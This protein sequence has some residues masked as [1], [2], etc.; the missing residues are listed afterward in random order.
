MASSCSV[1]RRP[2]ICSLFLLKNKFRYLWKHK[3]RKAKDGTDQRYLSESS[4]LKINS[5]RL[6]E[7]VQ[8]GCTLAAAARQDMQP[9]LSSFHF[10]SIA[11]HQPSAATTQ[12][13][14][15]SIENP[16]PNS[17]SEMASEKHSKKEGKKDRSSHGEKK[18]KRDHKE[19]GEASKSKKHRSKKNADNSVASTQIDSPFHVQ[20]ASL[21]LPLAPISQG[22][23]LEGLCAEHLSPLLL[24]FYPPL[25]GVVLSYNNVTLSESPHGKDESKELLMQNIDEYAVSYCWVTATFLLFKP[26]PGVELEGYVNLQNQG[27]LGIVCWNLFNA[28]IEAKRLPKG[29]RWVDV[30]ELDSIEATE[31]NEN[32]GYAE[33]GV[34]CWVDENN[35]KIEGQIKFR[36][37]EVES[38][39]DRERGFLSLEGTLLSE[40]DE[41]ELA[42]EEASHITTNGRK[43]VS[44]GMKFGATDLSVP[45]E[46]G[47]MDEDD[48]FSKKHRSRY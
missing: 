6:N 19:D 18:R 22:Y 28:S 24:T 31:A 30:S 40:E 43:D 5:P 48:P 1:L 12:H 14:A 46:K 37:K 36:V 25:Q 4:N 44:A 8:M 33:D 9:S 15:M 2:S 38:S 29:W 32:G 42:T 34:G 11:Q 21:Y 7:R 3:K 41:K 26:T 13:I 47:L 27:H 17:T 35:K 20:S 39:S 23:P 16:T 10:F 45:V